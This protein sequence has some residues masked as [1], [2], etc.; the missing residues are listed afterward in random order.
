MLRAEVQDPE[1][2][3]VGRQ[4]VTTEREDREQEPQ[5]ARGVGKGECSRKRA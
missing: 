5:T 2:A 3:V 1:G 4:A